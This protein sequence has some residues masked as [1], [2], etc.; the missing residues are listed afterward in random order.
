MSLLNQFHSIK[1]R[2]IDPKEN[3]VFTICQV[4]GGSTWDTLPEEVKLVGTIRSY[5][6]EPKNVLFDRIRKIAAGVASSF[7]CEIDVDLNEIYPAVLNH[8]AQTQHVIRLCKQHLGE[9]HFSDLELPLSASEDFSYFLQKVPGCFFALGTMKQGRKI[10]TLHTSDYDYND[11]VLP[12]GA[13]F[14]TKIVEDR[15]GVKLLQS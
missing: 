11:D 8:P 13:F 12:S 2:D 1:S 15:L 3:L 7:D 9:A 4:D 5:E 10:Q 6:E 14:F